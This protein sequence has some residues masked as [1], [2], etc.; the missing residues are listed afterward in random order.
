M[1]RIARVV[2]ADVFSV[3]PSGSREF[4]AHLEGLLGRVLHP[5]KAGRKPKKPKNAKEEAGNLVSVPA[6]RVTSRPYARSATAA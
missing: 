5:Q 3:F 6:V 1:A 2:V 4:V